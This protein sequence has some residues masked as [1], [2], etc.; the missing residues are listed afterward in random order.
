MIISGPNWTEGQ[1]VHGMAMQ[2]VRGLS[3]SACQAVYV[4]FCRDQN[5][6]PL[7]EKPV[8]SKPVIKASV[9]FIHSK[10]L[11]DNIGAVENVTLKLS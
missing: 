2:S 10:A 8:E 9:F 7:K 1:L 4:M 3:M 6:C 5:S 11:R